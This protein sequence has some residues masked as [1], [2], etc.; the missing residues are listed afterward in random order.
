[1]RSQ[2]GLDYEENEQA[3]RQRASVTGLELLLDEIYDTVFSSLS[4]PR[5]FPETAIYRILQRRF[6]G[7]QLITSGQFRCPSSCEIQRY[8]ATQMRDIYVPI[9]DENG[10][11]VPIQCQ[12]GGQCWCVDSVGREVYGSRVVG[13]SPKCDN[14]HKCTIKRKQALSTLF[15]GPTGHFGQNNLFLTQ[16]EL[17]AKISSNVC[18]SYV[19]ERFS[20]S[21]MGLEL[22][23][24][25]GLPLSAFISD[26][27]QGLFQSKD[28]IQLALRF[29][30]SP[31]FQQ[32]LFGGKYLKNLGSFNFTGAIGTKN[33]FSFSDFF[34]QIGLTEMYSGGN[35]K[36]LAK[37]FSSEED[38]YLTRDANV[39]KPV[40]NLDQP[41][42]ASFGRTVKLQENQR[43]VGFFSSVL[44]REEFSVLLRDIISIPPYV[45]EDIYEAM[46]IIMS[47]KDCEKRKENVFVPTC[48]KDGTYEQIQCGSYECWCVDEQG[49]EVQGSRTTDKTP[50]CP[51]KC[52]KE[53]E[54]QILLRRGQPAGSDLFIPACDQNGHYA[55]VQCAGKYCFCVDL[56]GRTIPETRK[57][58]GG[59]IQCPSYCQLTASNAFLPATNRLLSGASDYSALSQVYIPQCAP[60]GEWQRGQCS[61]PTEQ[62]FALYER[63]TTLNRNISLQETLSILLTYKKSSSQSFPD[64][65]R[66]LYEEGHQSIFPVLSQYP[67][68][69][70]IPEEFFDGNNTASSTDNFLLNP[71]IFWR[72]LS[73]SLTY[74]PGSYSDF[75]TP[76]GHMDQRSCWCADLGGQ[77]LPGMEMVS[78]K[79]P[80]CPRSCQL[81][82]MKSQQFTEVAENI[83]SAS[84]SSHLPLGYNFLLANGIRLSGSDLMYTEEHKSIIALSERFLRKDTYALQLAAYSTLKFF[85][86]SRSNVGESKR[87][88]YVPYTPQC[89]GLGYWSPLQ[90]YQGTGHYW[91][92]DNE[93]N[94]IDGS[95]TSRT[96]TPPQCQTSCQQAKAKSQLSSW[97]PRKSST[98]GNA[99]PDGFTPKCTE[100][101]RFASSQSSDSDFWCVSSATGE[102]LP[103][104]DGDTL[105][106][107]KCPGPQS[108]VQCDE[109]KNVCYCVLPDGEEASGTRVTVVDRSS[110]LCQAPVCPLPFGVQ[111]VRHGSLFCLEILESG[112]KLQKCQL[113]CQ[114][115]YTNVFS[116]YTY[117]CDQKTQMWASPPPHAQPCQRVE[118]YHVVQTQAWFQLLLPTGKMCT[119]DYSGLLEAFRTFI[120][121]DLQARGLCHIQVRTYGSTGTVAVCDSSTIRVECLTSSRMGV[122]VTWTAQAKGI[123]ESSLPTVHDIENALATQDLVGRL[124]SVVRS[125]SYSLNLDSK[126][127]VADKSDFL[128]AD[129]STQVR[130]GCEEG[131]Q[132]LPSSRVGVNGNAGGCGMCPAGSYSQ[133]GECRPCSRGFYQDKPG[134]SQ[135]VKCPLGTSTAYTG[136]YNESQCVT[137]CQ[138]NSRGL[139]CDDKGQFLP[140]QRGGTNQ[141]YYCVDDAGEKLKWTET[142]RELQNDQCLLLRRFEVVPEDRLMVDNG[143]T[144]AVPVTAQRE[145]L[146]DCIRDCAQD[147]SCD[148]VAVYGNGS[149][150]ICQQ[151]S[152]EDSNIICTAD[153]KIQNT[154]GN[155][156]ASSLEELRCQH[157]LKQS[158]ID[159][160]TAYRKKGGEFTASSGDFVRTDFGNVLSGVYSST[161]F[162]GGGASLTD[163]YLLCRQTCRQDACCHGFVLSQVILNKGTTICGLLSSPDVLLCHVNDWSTR[164][165]LG[166]D[167]VCGEVR[168]NKEKKMF[169]F[170][171]GGQEFTG[172]YTLLSQSVGMVEYSTVLTDDI[173]EEIQALFTSF[174]RVYLRTDVDKGFSSASRCP[175]TAPRNAT[176]VSGSVRD[177]FFAVDGN[178]VVVREDV[179]IASAEYWISR[180]RYSA[181]LA[182][183][184]CLSRCLEEE[185]WCRLA[186]LRDSAK[187]FFSCI[188]YPDTW[189]CNNYTEPLP[190]NCDILLSTKPQTLY[191]RKDTVSDKVKHFYT[192]LP[193]RKLTEI[194]V[195][196][197]VPVTGA[198]VSKGFFQCELYC[199]SDPCCRGF[200]YV[201]RS[202]V[203]GPERQCVMVADLGVQ[204]CP[205]ATESSFYVINCSFPDAGMETSPYGWYK[206]PDA[207]GSVPPGLC[208]AVEVVKNTKPV[209][210][211]DW[212]LLDYSSVTTDSSLSSYD[213]VEI[214]RS[215]SDTPSTAQIYCL[216][217]CARL[218]ACVTATIDVQQNAM[219]CVFYPETQRC[220]YRLTGHHCQL[221]VRDSATYIFR[222]RAPPRPPASVTI[223]QG[224]I[225]GKSQAVLIGEDLKTVSQF[226]GIPYAAPPTGEERFRPPQPS[227]WTGTWNATA[228]RWNCLQPGDGKAQ[229]ASVSEDCLYLNV[230]VPRN[231][232]PS[233]AVL[234]F[235]YNSPS[236]YSENGQT[237]IDGSYQ[238][239]LGDIIVVTA[240][241][242]VGVFG[243]LSAGTAVPS[244]NWGLLDQ[245]AAL[246][247]VQENIAYFG[248]DP[249]QI[250]IGAERAGADVASLHLLLPE[251]KPFRR[252][253]LMG[254]SAFTPL[255]I[256][257]KKRAQEQLQSLAEEVGCAAAEE[258]GSL[259]CLRKVDAIALNAA[260]TKLLAIR[261]PFQTWGPVVDGTY[262]RDT[263]SR[264]LLQKSSQDID[265]LIGST[266]HDG[267]I[268][269]AKAIKRFEES[270]GR[271]D[272]KMAFYQALQNSLGGEERNPLVQEA[273]V[274]YYSLQHSTDDYSSF[275]RALENSTRDHFITCPAVKMA[276]HWSESTKGDVYMYHVP[277]TYS[278]SST[279]LDLPEDVLYAFGVPF[280]ANYRSQFSAEEKALS[281][282]IMQYLANFVKSGNPNFPYSYSR[283][284]QEALPPWPVY[285]TRSG[286]RKYKELSRTLQTEQHLKQAECSFW[287]DYIPALKLSTSV[288][289]SAGSSEQGSESRST[290]AVTPSAP[291]Q[292]K[293]SYN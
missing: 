27:I 20:D 203:Q 125:G 87:L 121:D 77:R 47:S 53:R 26:M 234:L 276:D 232:R 206:K 225:V 89:D 39:S 148:Y 243:F 230:Y 44:E 251:R 107:N 269:R 4:A 65:V 67:S 262:L 252:A 135:C 199:D 207:P 195:R 41:I 132:K 278:Q 280:H 22:A 81:A 181:D 28:Q 183:S 259:A 75:S 177:R 292:D 220:Y 6:L 13:D 72:L 74:Y 66:R 167:G 82:R 95:L 69:S 219:K 88:S 50:K 152:G 129:S 218:P 12:V 271:G 162:P 182:L 58:S 242:R 192:R 205:E 55:T 43:R 91:C 272:S 211:D 134:K 17:G 215:Y 114:E 179:A 32:N 238:A 76:L 200:G 227:A 97:V 226:L 165:S 286:G 283:K 166:G 190:S 1:M 140:A 258:A 244:G 48:R 224:T 118:S 189:N 255:L 90:A 128:P 83:V 163:A 256:V 112:E 136:A 265:L 149:G 46:K 102:L 161:L 159:S 245:A 16:E 92:V 8:T 18:P 111:E 141:L 267:L 85:Q 130:L 34:Q 237:F 139:R 106:N 239:A 277:E 143:N 250:C 213:T 154:L 188:L 24:N 133:E 110:T 210:L 80:K 186:D 144:E 36:E 64:F 157:R 30:S 146:L 124:L 15:H 40:F 288:K 233:T 33:K 202:G 208:P 236:D 19:M 180:D 117:T 94:Y 98:P 61:G 23:R 42:L 198:S 151:Y 73:G 142:D 228:I 127:F 268:S 93:G 116:T 217:E 21:G 99:A 126:L 191:R 170:F 214:S 52:Q 223:P 108:R 100:S 137:R 168:S 212:I 260:Q 178:K 156:A 240:G 193:Y 172:S 184:W 229:Y 257:S 275:S 249:E 119:D 254:G 103:L 54:S 281:L 31:R 235:F 216:S 5:A 57:L 68:F 196:N 59:N 60:S 10:D 158:A 263:P 105:E 204:S 176:S 284:R 11:F 3:D 7:V 123:P 270:Q 45:A 174:Q 38:S 155:S 194:T 9:C 241:Y 70:D 63:W 248:G 279:S 221:L 264:L 285:R 291:K 79:I 197:I 49:L 150:V 147:G 222:K 201:R 115:G 273:A 101:G 274:W 122:N 247:W 25:L 169:S 164:S 290:P 78:S 96:S 187:E 289:N 35:F 145:S 62:T 253:V 282:Q 209:P 37:L 171:L 71:Y 261:G 293:E 173:K 266:E 86:E 231:T 14:Y 246:K 104:E 113:M 138:A 153:K 175:P 120:L 160:V 51:S 84:N 109:E 287:N 2:C 56:E 131:Y 185:S 29:A